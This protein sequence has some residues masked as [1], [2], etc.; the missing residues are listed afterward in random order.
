MSNEEVNSDTELPSLVEERL[1]EE[2]EYLTAQKLHSLTKENT[3]R[4][5]WVCSCCG[6]QV[7]VLPVEGLRVC[8]HCYSQCEHCMF[9]YRKRSIMSHAVRS[10]WDGKYVFVCRYCYYLYYEESDEDAPPDV[11]EPEPEF[12]FK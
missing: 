12:N 10:Q 8:N 3:Y 4:S 6:E 7:Y 9:Y 5:I 2:R 11:K 1:R